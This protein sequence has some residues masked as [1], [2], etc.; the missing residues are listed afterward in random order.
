MDFVDDI[1]LVAG[2]VGSIVDLLTKAA[3]VINTGVT[4]GVNFYDIQSSTFGDCLAH[5]A[6]IAGLAVTIGEAIDCLSKAACGAGLAGPTRTTEK[7]G[8]GYATTAESVE[9][10]MS[11]RFLP[12]YF[13]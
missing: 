9:E 13:S 3:D 12:N 11:Y 8:M 4:G 1:D 6:G 5:G 2:L 7:I 10:C